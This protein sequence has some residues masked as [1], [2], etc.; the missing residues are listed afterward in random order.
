MDLQRPQIVSISSAFAN[1]YCAKSA[2]KKGPFLIS[3]L[4]GFLH[5]LISDEFYENSATYFTSHLV[6]IW[7]WNICA[8]RPVLFK[9]PKPDVS[10]TTPLQQVTPHSSASC[11]R[12][13][14]PHRQSQVRENQV[15]YSLKKQTNKQTNSP[16]PGHCMKKSFQ[17]Y[18]GLTFQ[19]VWRFDLDEV[20]VLEAKHINNCS[21]GCYFFPLHWFDSSKQF[22]N[23]SVASVH[24]TSR[25]ITTFTAAHVAHEKDFEENIFNQILHFQQ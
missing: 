1:S 4:S 12:P 15:V 6:Q 25:K 2:C 14:T 23:F 16:P 9:A 19:E 17:M 10:R 3:A 20:L 21:R 18:Y 22:C 7:Q 8:S 13:T 11:A 5:H 24:S